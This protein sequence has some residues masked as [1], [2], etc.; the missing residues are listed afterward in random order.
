MVILLRQEATVRSGGK[1]AED[2]KVELLNHL[3][4]AMYNFE[5]LVERDANPN[6][7]KPLA[8]GCRR[9]SEGLLNG[10]ATEVFE[11]RKLIVHTMAPIEEETERRQRGR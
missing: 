5:T 9:L 2:E 4:V 6:V 11:G 8:E 3:T 1:L 7:V 10:D